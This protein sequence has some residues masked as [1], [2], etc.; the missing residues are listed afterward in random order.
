MHTRPGFARLRP[1][2]AIAALAASTAALLACERPQPRPPQP[3]ARMVAV[4]YD[5]GCSEVPGPVPAHGILDADG[6]R[7]ELADMPGHVLAGLDLRGA[8]WSRVTLHD[9]DLSGCDFRGADLRGADFT[10]ATVW[11]CD[12]TG[13][14]V[15]HAGWTTVGERA[16]IPR[17]S[18][19]SATA[20]PVA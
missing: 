18:A 7:W 19:S 3:I 4:P 14:D 11:E 15:R 16:P 8:E 17:K 6:R 13:A 12:F 9:A 1:L 20:P 5:G 2:L 10:K